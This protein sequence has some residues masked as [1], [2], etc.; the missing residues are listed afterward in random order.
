MSS[1]RGM[2]VQCVTLGLRRRK[3]A[4]LRA[5][6]VRIGALPRSSLLLLQH[7]EHPGSGKKACAR[8]GGREGGRAE[9]LC[10]GLREVGKAEL[11]CSRVEE[12]CRE[13]EMKGGW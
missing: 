13:G 7:T 4:C 1:P 3:L 11:L 2:R 5:L 9:L 10:T 8:A 12:A 6:E